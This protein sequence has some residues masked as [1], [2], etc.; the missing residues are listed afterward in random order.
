MDADGATDISSLLL[1]SQQQTDIV[2]GS[3]A[4][5]VGTS[6]VRKRSFLRNLLMH[7]FH[8]FLKLFSVDNQIND[9]Q[10]GFKLFKRAAAQQLFTRL[11]LRGWIFDIELLY[12]AN[13]LKMTVTEVPVDWQEKSGSKL[14]VAK[15]SVKMA[16]DVVIMKSMY[17]FGFW[18]SR[19]I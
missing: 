4:H 3:R 8:K 1:L 16:L 11:H 10:C 5:L 13:V 2:V 17:Y 12:L 15:D 18:K 6:A 19:A 14:N 7:A 9:T